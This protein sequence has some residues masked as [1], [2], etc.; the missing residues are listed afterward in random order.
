MVEL[1]IDR[2]KVAS[3]KKIDFMSKAKNHPFMLMY[4][5]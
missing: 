5:L 1:D 2:N 4:L 3:F